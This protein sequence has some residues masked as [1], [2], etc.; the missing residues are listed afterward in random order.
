MRASEIAP[1]RRSNRSEQPVWGFELLRG[2]LA[3]L[4]HSKRHACLTLTAEVIRD[5]QQNHGIAAWVSGRKSLFFPPD[6]ARAGIDLQNLPIVKAGEA[7]RAVRMTD[8]LIRSGGFELVIADLGR[9]S[10]IPTGLQKRLKKHIQQHQNSALFLTERPPNW[11]RAGSLISFRGAGIRKQARNTDTFDVRAPES[12][13]EAHKMNREKPESIRD[14]QFWCELEALVDKRHGSG[15]SRR[16]VYR[17]PDG[18]R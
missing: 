1:S 3:E 5:V 17:G 12:N 8:D 11:N 16:E 4:S 14:G 2:Q 10:S 6:I 13:I 7:D 18:L 15:W 9:I